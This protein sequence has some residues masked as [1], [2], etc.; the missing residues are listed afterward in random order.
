MWVTKKQLFQTVS[1]L[2]SEIRVLRRRIYDQDA[3]HAR[4]LE[5]LGLK[6]ETVPGRVVMLKTHVEGA[7]Q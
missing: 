2:E 4:L 5:H 3:A 7:K 1:G 6:E